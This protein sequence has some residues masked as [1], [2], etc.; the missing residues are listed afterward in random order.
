MN[1]QEAIGVLGGIEKARQF[2]QRKRDGW[3]ADDSRAF[4]DLAL[5]ALDQPSPPGEAAIA[6]WHKQATSR[7]NAYGGFALSPDEVGQ[8]VAM[9]RA[10]PE[11]LLLKAAQAVDDW[12]Q[13]N[14]GIADDD[15]QAAHEAAQQDVDRITEELHNALATTPEPE[16]AEL[17][18]LRKELAEANDLR[19]F[20]IAEN[21]RAVAAHDRCYA[22]VA[23]LRAA[24]GDA[25]L[26]RLK[27]TVLS[28]RNM[29]PR[30][31]VPPPSESPEGAY[32]AYDRVAGEI[33]RLLAEAPAAVKPD[34]LEDLVHRF[35]T[36]LL[37]K[38]RHAH[39]KYGF[40]NEWAEDGWE[41]ECQE[42]LLKHLAK[43]DPRDVA[44]YCA[45]LWHHGWSTKRELAARERR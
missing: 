43:G 10:R 23:E 20:Y 32:V 1:T 2:I 18:R 27:S 41:A 29:H 36:A 21:D 22:M 4:C 8:A 44:A 31:S 7:P 33:D 39:E 37:A 5:A 13:G 6:A 30:P 40:N 28:A 12:L 45:F 15:T 19:T 3:S 17:E 26:R 16:A 34:P 25:K 42:S 24:G 9:M 35:S 14:R 38:L 11:S